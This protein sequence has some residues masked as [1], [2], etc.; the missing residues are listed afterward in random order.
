MSIPDLGL[1]IHFDALMQTRNVSRAA[2]RAGITQPSMS[3]ALVRLRKLFHDPLLTREGSVWT[4][5]PRA[6]EVHRDMKPLLDKWWTYTTLDEEFHPEHSRRT[7]I[8]YATD[9]VQFRL[10]PKLL[11]RLSVDAPHFHIK[12]VPAKPL[13]GLHMLDTNH[14]E[15][16][17]GYFPAALPELRTRFMFQ[18]PARCIVRRGH[19]CLARRWNLDEYLKHQHVDLSAHTGYFSSEIASLLMS[20]N[21]KRDVVTTLSSY[22]V[23]PYVVEQS[24]LIATLPQSIAD[25]ARRNLGI[26]ILDVPFSIPTLSISLYWHER[27]HADPAHA[28]LRQYIAGIFESK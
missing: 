5:T 11:A 22:L 24:D 19:P 18:E 16:I 13:H 6:I 23:C 20:Q 12:V 25:E 14:A 10:V 15:L 26:E 2:D 27:Y 9:Y 21:K 4:P 8:L 7:L 17:A 1:L 3:A 28:W